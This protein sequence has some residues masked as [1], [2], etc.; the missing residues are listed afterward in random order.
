MSSQFLDCTYAIQRSDISSEHRQWSLCAHYRSEGF[1]FVFPSGG[2]HKS[3]GNSH[4]L[5]PTVS[6]HR[7]FHSERSV[8]ALCFFTI[9]TFRAASSRDKHRLRYRLEVSAGKFDTLA[10]RTWEQVFF[11]RNPRVCARTMRGSVEASEPRGILARRTIQ[12]HQKQRQK[13]RKSLCN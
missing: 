10:D 4:C 11:Q 3:P 2:S 8:Y 1:I 6:S 9:V 7:R 5:A 12:H 13:T